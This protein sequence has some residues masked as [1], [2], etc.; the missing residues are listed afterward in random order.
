M[1]TTEDDVLILGAGA[2]GVACAYALQRAGR[3]VRVLDRGAIGGATSYGNCGTITPSHAPPLAAPGMIAQGLRWM[4]RPDAPFRVAPGFEWRRWHWLSRAAL[5]CRSGIH[6]RNT[7]VRAAL[8]LRSRALTQEWIEH[9]RIDCD[10]AAAGT[11][12][13]FRDA[14]DLVRAANKQIKALSPLG[15]ATEIWDAERTAATEPCL[16]PGIAGA[17]FNPQDAHLRPDRFVSGIAQIVRDGGGIIDTGIELTGWELRDG[18]AVGVR[19]SQGVH[20]ARDI[21]VALGPWQSEFVRKLGTALPIEPGKGYSV[22]YAEP[23]ALVPKRPL[24]LKDASV[25]VTTWAQGFRLGSTMEFA[26]FD[27]TLNQR[28]LAALIDASRR[29]LHEPEGRGARTD[30]YGWRPMTP[31]DLPIIDRAS[32]ASNVVLAGGHG[33]MGMSLCA[34]TGELVAAMLGN[35]PPAFDLAPFSAT[36][37]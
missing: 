27:N 34:V 33:M 6:A 12:Y 15:I 2:V 9:E 18:R 17:L 29:Y 20:R 24:V 22:T 23:P 7:V 25:C 37:F 4:L 10:F 13:V 35:A 3:Q 26:G 36:R 11:L 28:R 31:D 32:R 21:V 30:W 16:L 19:S 8:L 14:A 1:S 5:N